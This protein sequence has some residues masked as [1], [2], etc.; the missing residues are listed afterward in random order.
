MAK[1]KKK[2]S[3]GTKNTYSR[4]D[5][6]PMSFYHEEDNTFE[7]DDIFEE[8]NAFEEDDIFEEDNAF[9]EQSGDMSR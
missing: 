8:D 5:T 4:N 3:F 9:E 6:V 1:K 7:E 2:K